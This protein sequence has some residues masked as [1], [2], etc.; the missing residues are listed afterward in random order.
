[1]LSVMMI[2]WIGII[3]YNCKGGERVKKVAILTCVAVM[4]TAVF[5][6]LMR[7]VRMFFDYLRSM[8]V[9]GSYFATTTTTV[10]DQAAVLMVF[11]MA[12]LFVLFIVDVACR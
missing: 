10:L 7:M 3:R 12:V 11:I 5:F 2:G 9:H 4:G 8:M 6:V 1:M